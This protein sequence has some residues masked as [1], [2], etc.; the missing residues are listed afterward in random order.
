[1]HTTPR[2]ATRK[3]RVVFLV[4]LH[5]GAGERFL[6]AYEAVRH[7]VSSVAGHLRDQVCRQDN[8]PDQWLITSEWQTLECFREWEATPEHRELA[9]P[10]RA[11]IAQARSLR[12][13]VI[14][15]TG[16]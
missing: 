5:A 9:A 12:F 3:G 13:E 6:T 14:E 10:L 1:V 8:D 16:R 4:R 11:C 2:E 15:E 7:E